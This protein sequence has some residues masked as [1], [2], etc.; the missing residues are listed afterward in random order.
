M[1]YLYLIIAIC[2]EVIATSA[3]KKSEAFTKLV[4]SLIV[5]VGYSASFY[6]LSLTL[7]H[8]KVGIVYAVWSG[9]GIVLVTIVGVFYFKQRV[10]LAGFLGLG[11]IIA[12]VVVLNV[13]SNVQTH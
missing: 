3:L 9:L 4:P 12:G 6:L 8:M 10:D 7:K 2:T 13:F 1:H 11:L 5:I